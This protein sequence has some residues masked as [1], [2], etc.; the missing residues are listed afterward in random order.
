[1]SSVTVLDALLLLIFLMRLL[2]RLKYSSVC[3][4]LQSEEVDIVGLDGHI[5]KGRLNASPG[6]NTDIKLPTI[7]TKDGK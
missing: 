1:M 4:V 5:Y 7:A 2:H 6:R 3:R